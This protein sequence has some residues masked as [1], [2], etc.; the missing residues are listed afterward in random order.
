MVLTSDKY[1]Y[2]SDKVSSFKNNY[3][4]LKDKTDDYVFSALCL[5]IIIIKIHP[6]NLMIL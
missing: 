3:Q 5:K 6:Y 1:K 4:F 2:I